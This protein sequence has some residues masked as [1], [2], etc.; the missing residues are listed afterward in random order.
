MH[1]TVPVQEQTVET[2][3]AYHCAVQVWML[4]IL[5]HL[6][7]YRRIG[8]TFS[9]DAEDIAG[10]LGLELEPG[11]DA[12]EAVNGFALARR[13]RELE[14]GEEPKDCVLK[15][16]LD[17]VTDALDFTATD[18]AIL[19]FVLLIRLDAVL[20]ATTELVGESLTLGDV[21]N[22]LGKIL[23][24]PAPEIKE[25]LGA[26]GR[27]RRAGLLYIEKRPAALGN[28][29][30]LLGQLI[31]VISIEHADPMDILSAF[32][33]PA[34]PAR[35]APSDFED[36]RRDYDLLRR[37]LEQA[38]AVR[39]QG[40][41]VLI[42]GA[43]GVGKTQ[44]VR[45]LV[46]DLGMKLFEVTSEDGD[47][48]PLSITSRLGAFRLTQHFLARR[49]DAVILFDEVEEVLSAN[50]LGWL[51]G[52]EDASSR[53]SWLNELLENN[54]VPVFWIAN[55]TE[56]IDPAHLRRFDF[57]FEMRPMSA[58]ARERLLEDVCREKGVPAGGWLKRAAQ[59]PHMSPAL[60]DKVT[61]VVAS[62]RTGGP[63][64]DGAVFERVANGTLEAMGLPVLKLVEKRPLIPYRMNVVNADADLAG[65]VAGLRRVKG[66]R[67]LC[68]GPPGT[69]KTAFARQLASDLGLRLLEFRASDILGPYVGLTEQKIARAFRTAR[70]EGAMMLLDEIDSLL[71]SREGAG[72]SWEVTQ[73]NELLVQME[74]FPG[75]LV[76][77][78]NFADGLD[79]A[80]A[81]R[82]DR[83]I[84]FGYLADDKA[85]VLF[86][87]TL[88][89]HGVRL[90]RGKGDLE[91]RLRA[92]KSLTPGDFKAA[93]R[94]AALTAEG[95]VPEALL[96]ALE[97][98]NRTK[99]ERAGRPIGFVAAM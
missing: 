56:R 76:A 6:R 87:D 82:F 59:S 25:A 64:D 3:A 30:M 23:G 22:A 93:V 89:H 68:Y 52:N 43:P 66:G 75:I 29:V 63:I 98:E 90:G 71:R 35:L 39:R 84:G 7:G 17:L 65:L 55:R 61:S 77:C 85:W 2:E 91:R 38:A 12:E 53:K 36:Y 21:A 62:T 78:T 96:A 72:H 41:N 67:I 32:V 50:D 33:D 44:L 37:N 57:V 34:P 86:K 5:V 51:F 11:Q 1:A 49:R 94:G 79:G 13:L 45:T 54:P 31:D 16:N 95:L 70:K 46:A 18:R 73:V 80:A 58:K 28:K 19:E 92:L 81:R 26:K 99:T 9:I 48:D 14:G 47:G 27:L 15:R 24:R 88:K 42:H 74:E 8:R 60:I 10:V 69:G 40:C 20:F 97:D 4:R 83:K